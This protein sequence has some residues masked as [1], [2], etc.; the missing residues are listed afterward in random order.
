MGSERLLEGAA[1]SEPK[2]ADRGPGSRRQVY[3]AI[4][5]A[6]AVTPDMRLGQLLLNV[7]SAPGDLFF[8]ENDR[9]I[10]LLN[11][12]TELRSKE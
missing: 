11:R 7:V 12:W 10:E 6:M 5:S 2:S 3:D 4:E 9:L 1:M 8:V